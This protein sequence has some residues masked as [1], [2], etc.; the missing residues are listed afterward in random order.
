MEKSGK[1]LF[2]SGSSLRLGFFCD[3]QNENMYFLAVG[4]TLYWTPCK[5]VIKERHGLKFV[6]RLTH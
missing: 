6:S 3:I 1:V 5:S 2:F 4:V